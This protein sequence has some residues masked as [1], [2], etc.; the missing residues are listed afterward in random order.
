M[1]TS[2]KHGQEQR[3]S[4]YGEPHGRDNIRSDL[5]GVDRGGGLS[6]RRHKLRLG[7]LRRTVRMPT[8]RAHIAPVTAGNGG[9]QKN[10]A[11]HIPNSGKQITPICAAPWEYAPGIKGGTVCLPDRRNTMTAIANNRSDKNR[12]EP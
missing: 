7:W 9:K 12:S 11:Q 8:R 6:H 1:T 2:A 3:R 5:S 4:R 10:Y